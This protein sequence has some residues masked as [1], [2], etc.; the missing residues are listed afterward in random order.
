MKKTTYSKALRDSFA[1]F[2]AEALKRYAAM[3]KHHISDHKIDLYLMNNT[4]LGQDRKIEEHI[5]FCAECFLRIRARGRLIAAVRI[6]KEM[7]KFTA[8]VNKQMLGK[9]E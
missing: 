1:P 9:G 3:K 2:R 5:I 4:T 8:T 6:S 7:K